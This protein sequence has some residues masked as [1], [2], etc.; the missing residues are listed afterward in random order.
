METETVTLALS[1]E[2][3]RK[4]EHIAVQRSISLSALLAQALEKLVQEEDEYMS[5]MRRQI[6]FM[7]NAPDL[8]TNGQK[9]SRDEL[10]ER[11]HDV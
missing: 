11:T 4:V 1:E 7:E 2:L 6:H 5:A 10:H 9:V 8:R 3:L